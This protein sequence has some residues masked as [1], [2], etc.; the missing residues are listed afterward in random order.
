M[1]LR[2]AVAVQS[3]APTPWRRGSQG[4]HRYSSLAALRGA[5]VAMATAAARPEA[6]LLRRHPT[7]LHPSAPLAAVSDH[8]QGRV[9]GTPGTL[10]PSPR[11]AGLLAPVSGLGC[12][13]A[14]AARAVC[15]GAGGDDEGEPGGLLG[16][17]L[18][19]TG[20]GLLGTG[21][22]LEL[23]AASVAVASAAVKEAPVL[24]LS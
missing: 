18:R 16:S 23:A 20:A 3:R 17:S 6:P 19:G 4:V 10:P 2:A 8:G 12:G 14:H 22:R 13:H 24:A 11:F 9:R 21:S 15:G 1:S 7:Q 5:G